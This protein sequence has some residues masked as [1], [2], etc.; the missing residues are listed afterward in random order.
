MTNYKELFQEKQ[1]SPSYTRVRIYSYLEDSKNHPTVDEIYK[2]LKEDLPTLSKT[3]VYNV[4]KLFIDKLL[5]KPVN[6]M[7]SETRYEV[8]DHDHSH[9]TCTECGTIYDIPKVNISYELSGLGDFDVID[10]TVNLTG[11]CPNCK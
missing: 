1:I 10:E 7:S 4:L 8:F 2:N 9:F 6:M 11:V 3:T 5:V